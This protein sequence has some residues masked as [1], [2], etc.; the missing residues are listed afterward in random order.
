MQVC[1]QAIAIIIV[2]CSSNKL[3][4]KVYYTWWDK[5]GY[6]QEVVNEVICVDDL[7]PRSEYIKL[8]ETTQYWWDT[9]TVTHKNDGKPANVLR[10]CR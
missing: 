7:A 6:L 5:W 10:S 3:S 1:H 9:V 2:S 8:P 4:G